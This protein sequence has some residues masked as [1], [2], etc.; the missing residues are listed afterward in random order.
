MA[1]QPSLFM[2]ANATLAQP[3]VMRDYQEECIQNVL[4]AYNRGLR[5][6]MAVLAT[7]LGK[8]ALVSELMRR[9]DITPAFSNRVAWFVAHRDELLRQGWKTVRQQIPGLQMGVEK[10]SLRAISTD[11]AIFASIATL[12]ETRLFSL[13]MRFR[14]KVALVVI[15]EAHRSASEQYRNLIAYVRESFPQALI[16]GITATPDRTDKVGMADLYEETVFY[17]PL[18]QAI[19]NGYLVPLIGRRVRTMVELDEVHSSKRDGDLDPAALAKLLDVEDRNKIA[20][21]AIRKHFADRKTMIFGA[22]VKHSQRLAD[23]LKDYGLAAEAVWGDTS[24]LSQKERHERFEA[25]RRRDLQYL[26][27]AD[28]FIEG[29]DDPDVDGIAWVRATEST[30]Y[31]NQGT[32]RGGRPHRSIARLLGPGT[33]AEERVALIRQSPKPNCLVLDVVDV[34]AKHSLQSLPMLFGLQAPKAR[35]PFAGEEGGELF[36]SS[37]DLDG[38]VEFRE[39]DDCAPVIATPRDIERPKVRVTGFVTED[40]DLLNAER[41]VD[42]AANSEKV[43][44]RWHSPQPGVRRIN[45][46]PAERPVDELGRSMPGF[47][48]AFMIAKSNGAPDPR[49]VAMATI[50][51]AEMRKAKLAAEIRTAGNGKWVGVVIEDGAEQTVCILDQ[52]GDVLREVETWLRQHYPGL[53]QRY[54]KTASWR[55]RKPTEGQ[56]KALTRI[57]LPIPQTSGEASDLIT[58]HRYKPVSA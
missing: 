41:Q 49:A 12:R 13:G 2:P 27:G 54:S 30:I 6:V 16:L 25:F 8:T 43:K 51:A 26:V 17:Y 47:G 52:P 40:V 53:V 19:R 11:Q 37:D 45:F 48:R 20:I 10:G 23:M 58:K 33:T 34:S 56:I 5:S 57:G 22:G 15:D 39:E 14:E 29:F 38:L 31:Y 42:E 55:T 7:G 1:A 3:L 35:Q 32:G 44:F 46:P 50:G 28:L 9:L 36:E 24:T 4:D 21:D 18:P